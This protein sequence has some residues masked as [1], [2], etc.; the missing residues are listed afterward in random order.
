MMDDLGLDVT[1]LAEQ[2]RS[3]RDEGKTVMFVVIEEGLAGFVAVADRIKPT[4]TAAIKAL[5]EHGL[6]IIMATGDN[7]H[8]ARAVARSL[9]IDEVRADILPEGKKILVDELRAK[10]AVVAMAGDGVN[11][12]PALAAADVGIA[13]G[14]GADVAMESAGL[15]LVKGDLNG[16]VR[17]RRLAMATMRNIRQNLGFAFGYN[18]LGVPLA[19]GVLYPVFGLLLSPMIAAAAMSLSSVSV[20][21]NALR[22]RLVKL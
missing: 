12:A 20:I 2:I 8:T 3:L 5:H 11:D 9:G 15:T 7:E 16:I 14:T 22:L 17:A 18:A 13:M 1:P 21:A 4:T 10:G 6:K 19:A